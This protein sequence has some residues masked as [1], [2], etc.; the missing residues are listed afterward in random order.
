MKYHLWHAGL[1]LPLGIFLP[2]GI[3]LPFG[4]VRYFGMYHLL[5]FKTNNKAYEDSRSCSLD[6]CSEYI[7]LTEPDGVSWEDYPYLNETFLRKNAYFAGYSNYTSGYHLINLDGL[8][9]L[10]KWLEDG[11]S[12]LIHNFTGDCCPDRSS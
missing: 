10:V 2:F 4:I 9:L 8:W 6:L 5:I 1:L 11:G 7:Q 12:V 3:L